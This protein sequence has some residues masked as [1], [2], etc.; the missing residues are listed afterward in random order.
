M[1]VAVSGGPPLKML[2]DHRAFLGAAWAADDT[3]IFSSVVGLNRVSAGGGG[4][5]ELLAGA[6]EAGGAVYRR[7]RAPA[8]WTRGAVYA[9]R[10][11]SERVAVLDLETREQ[12]I[13]IEDAAERFLCRHGPYRLCHV[14]RR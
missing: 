2:D 8:G 7:A 14:A 5:P 12:S 3:L 10:G 9:P 1:R 13:L 6:T 4:T 11:R